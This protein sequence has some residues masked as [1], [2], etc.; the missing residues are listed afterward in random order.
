MASDELLLLVGVPENYR[1]GGP[2]FEKLH[3]AHPRVRVQIVH[4]LSAY[5]ELVP[6]ADA[7]IGSRPYLQLSPEV[8]RPGGRLRWVQT[9]TAGVDHV[10]NP[11]L[12]AAEHVMITCIKGPPGPLMAEHAILL[13]LA[14]TRQFPIYLKNQERHIWRREGQEWAP[15]HGKT[16]AILGVGSSGGSL[17]RVCKAGF[18]MTV[19]GMTRSRGEHPDVDLYFTQDDLLQFL[20]QA[21]FVALCLPRT[22]QTERIIDADAL[23]AMQPMAFLVNVSRGALIDEDALMAALQS[24]RIAGAGLDVT[25]NDPI[26]AESPLWDLPNIIITPHIATETLQMSDAVVDFWCENV[27]RFAD[28]EPLLGLMDRQAGY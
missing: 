9:T 5:R 3:R 10:L 11:A 14:L 18:G 17:A 25:T 21:D 7:V 1:L 26:P 20:H 15:L 16:I 28:D 12:L 2:A 6:Q 23:Q 27:R 19:L 8:L 24:G 13:M 22:P 4:D